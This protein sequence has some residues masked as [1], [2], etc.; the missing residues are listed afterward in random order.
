[1]S[2]SSEEKTVKHNSGD[3]EKTVK[4]NSEDE[5]KFDNLI[6]EAKAQHDKIEKYMSRCNNTQ[7]TNEIKD[8][9]KLFIY[10]VPY[11]LITEKL[12]SKSYT[13]DQKEYFNNCVIRGLIRIKEKIK[14]CY[15]INEEIDYMDMAI[16]KVEKFRI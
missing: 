2:N 9:L 6:K 7:N 4:H 11:L 12:N 10:L 16:K 15:I 3:E 13:K 8:C 14:E 5:E 1:M